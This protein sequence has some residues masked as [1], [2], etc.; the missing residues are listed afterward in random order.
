MRGSPGGADVDA[1]CVGGVV[2][3]DAE[4]LP[5][6]GRFVLGDAKEERRRIRGHRLALGIQ[7][8]HQRRR[9][10]VLLDDVGAFFILSEMGMKSTRVHFM[11][12]PEAWLKAR[13]GGTDGQTCGRTR[14]NSPIL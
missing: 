4:A 3:G 2:D 11:K 14:Q 13:G 1:S 8:L 5:V 9:G 7:Q 10:A 6:F 12:A